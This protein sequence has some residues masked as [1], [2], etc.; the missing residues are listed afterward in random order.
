MT[1]FNTIQRRPAGGLSDSDTD[2]L[3]DDTDAPDV[4]DG[5]YSTDSESDAEDA[6][7]PVHVPKVLRRAQLGMELGD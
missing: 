4:L 1:L 6:A 5:A 7:P 3:G 2:D